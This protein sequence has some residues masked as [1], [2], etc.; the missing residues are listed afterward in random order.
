MQDALA[1]YNETR[2]RAAKAVVIESAILIATPA[3]V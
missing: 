1:A 3:P 2:E